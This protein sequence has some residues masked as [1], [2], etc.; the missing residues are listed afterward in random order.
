[1]KTNNT[2]PFSITG[3]DITNLS[4]LQRE[5]YYTELCNHLGLD[6]AM[7][8][9]KALR[10]R[11]RHFLY[12]DHGGVQ[13]LNQLH[14]I[15]HRILSRETA[16]GC[17]VV[18][19]QATAPGYRTTESIGAVSI[20]K[21]AGNRLCNAMMQA[22]TKAKHRASLDLLGLGMF[23]ESELF[24]LPLK[25][26]LQHAGTPLPLK[27]SPLRAGEDEGGLPVSLFL[28]SEGL[29]REIANCRDA[30]SLEIL[31]RANKQR[32]NADAMLKQLLEERKWEL[33]EV[34][35]A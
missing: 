12:C 3:G 17:Y 14:R 25:G 33:E 10:L 34:A 35:A 7:Q 27:P 20:S 23:D 18:T 8:P 2:N 31:C 24:P 1:M 11:G 13:M 30:E 29:K 21:L 5:V 26:N 9:F 15:S 4:P 32:I 16:N 22:E 28:S 6:P 19:A